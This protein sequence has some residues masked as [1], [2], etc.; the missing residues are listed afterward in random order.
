MKKQDK[1]SKVIQE[2]FD[3]GVSKA[4]KTLADAGFTPA[5]FEKL[6]N[7]IERLKKENKQLQNEIR[8]VKADKQAYAKRVGEQIQR[9][10]EKAS[11]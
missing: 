3:R 9:L 11:K 5:T 6:S 4:E 10:T 2:A 7:E 8:K 1:P